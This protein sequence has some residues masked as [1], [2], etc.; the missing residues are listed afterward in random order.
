MNDNRSLITMAVVALLLTGAAAFLV[1][2]PS[3]PAGPETVGPVKPVQ[4]DVRPD[5]TRSGRLTIEPAETIVV[6]RTEGTRA[7]TARVECGIFKADR[8]FGEEDGKA[9]FDVPPEA[10]TV[11]LA[12]TSGSYGPIWG[13]DELECMVV[14]GATACLGGLANDN[15]GLVSVESALG[16]EL[17]LDGDF[18]GELP[19]YELRTK[20][21][22]FKVKVKVPEHNLIF[23]YKL[24]VQPGE[25]V[26]LSFPAPEGFDPAA[27]PATPDSEAVPPAPQETT[28]G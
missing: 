17:H 19:L 18:L 26:H 24:V 25:T 14:D 7:K 21:G 5:V 16:G 12:S 23:P 3:D 27:A 6:T 13:G 4:G 1:L 10:C 9:T 11:E 28:D 2:N 22:T 8:S 20:P 15:P